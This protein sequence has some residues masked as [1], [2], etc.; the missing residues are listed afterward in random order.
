MNRGDL[1]ASP[2]PGHGYAAGMDYHSSPDTVLGF[3]LA[4]GAQTY[5]GSGTLRYTW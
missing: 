3:A 4:A 5:V 1:H 2:T